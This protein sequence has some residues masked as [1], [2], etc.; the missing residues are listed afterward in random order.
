MSNGTGYEASL[1]VAADSRFSEIRRKMGIS[2]SMHDFGRVAIVCRMIHEVSNQGI[3]Y[4]CF[5]YGRT[6][7]VLPLSD[8]ESSIV[9]TTPSYEADH[10]MNM[11]E[12]QFN[13]DVR[14]QFDG[15]LGHMALSG[16]RFAYPLV[17]V[18]AH[19]FFAKR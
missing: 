17:A 11:A 10:F 9:I 12:E 3:A 14:Q 16:E 2:A 19:Q 4:E 7:A 1:V 18:W 8:T 6:L 15:G 5:H 13:L